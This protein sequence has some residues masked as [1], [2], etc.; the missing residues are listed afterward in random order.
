MKPCII[1]LSYPDTENKIQILNNTIN[2]VKD[3]MVD[4]L[5]IPLFVFSN[6]N[7]DRDKL[8]KV[9]DF[10]YS[11]K[12]KMLSAL[13][14]FT[15]E[16]VAKARELTKYRHNLV[17]QH[18]NISYVPL[19]Y[20]TEKNYYWALTELYQLAFNWVNQ[21]GYTHFMLLQELN[22][23][24][25]EIQL[26]K[27]Y[28]GEMNQRDLDGIVAFEPD[29][30]P[31]H[32]SDFVFFGKSK[33][34]SELFNDMTAEDFYFTS[35]PNFTVEEYY[36][37]K[38]I[39]KGGNIKYKV[40]L[41]LDENQLDYWNDSP[42]TWQKES[43]SINC[44]TTCTW[45]L[46]FPELTQENFINNYESNQFDVVKWIDIS[47]L[48]NDQTHD[49]FVFNKSNTEVQISIISSHPGVNNWSF[50]LNPRFFR[51]IATGIDLKGTELTIAY[52]YYD[53]S[54]KCQTKF[55]QL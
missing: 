15:P 23:G 24:E 17:T 6:L 3:L 51:V 13:D 32:M 34:W 36:H 28:F 33:W 9:D 49:I 5:S 43:L 47:V 10:I 21:S 20:G 40:R 12:N 52:T 1:I 19:T 7:I 25:K 26:V 22:L 41:R 11:G 35:F 27:T 50:Q 2:S 38:L 14:F 48:P 54:E 39:S 29:Q 46:F 30:G 45:K 18:L 37:K 53:G 55:Y 31:H 44:D 42:P 16:I 8:S 4:N